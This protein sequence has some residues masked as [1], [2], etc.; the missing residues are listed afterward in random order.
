[1]EDAWADVFPS[2][3]PQ[4]P[5]TDELLAVLRRWEN[6]PHNREGSDKTWVDR[7][8]A[9]SRRHWRSAVLIP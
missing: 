8:D 4:Y 3:M 7:L 9:E 1:V 6:E 2:E 5:L